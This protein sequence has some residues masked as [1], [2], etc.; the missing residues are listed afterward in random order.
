[1]LV[2]NNFPFTMC[3][4]LRCSRGFSTVLWLSEAPQHGAFLYAYI[5]PFSMNPL[6]LDTYTDH[7]FSAAVIQCRGCNIAGHSCKGLN[8]G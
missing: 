8:I 3:G 4:L 2:F 6:A 7:T 1:M 5:T